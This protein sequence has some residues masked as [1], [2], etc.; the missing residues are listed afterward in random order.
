MQ[1]WKVI[2]QDSAGHTRVGRLLLE[3]IQLG[4]SDE[5]NWQ[6]IQDVFE[7]KSTSTLRTR[8]ASLLAFGRWK[9]SLH[10]DESTSIFPMSEDVAYEYLCDL[11]NHSA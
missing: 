11:R 7:N 1:C 4:K 5:Y 10:G 9:K 8:A 6:V 2:I 3:G